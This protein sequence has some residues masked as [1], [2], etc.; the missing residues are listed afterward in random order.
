MVM[1]LVQFLTVMVGIERLL[2]QRSPSVSLRSELVLLLT[3][4]AAQAVGL[5]MVA[6]VHTSGVQNSIRV[7]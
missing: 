2:Q 4:Q 6:L 7:L 1:R 5:V 3:L